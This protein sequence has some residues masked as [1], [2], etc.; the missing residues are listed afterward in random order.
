MGAGRPG[1]LICFGVASTFRVAAPLPDP[2][3]PVQLK[4]YACAPGWLGVTA[5]E[6]LVDWFPVHAPEAVQL[7]AL[8]D[9]QVSVAAAPAIT[10]AVLNVTETVGACTAGAAGP[11][12]PPPQACNDPTTIVT[13]AAILQ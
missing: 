10:L 9:D 12:V 6:P 5:T 4:L 3:A 13:I 1:I 8:V 2:P 7:V 11:P